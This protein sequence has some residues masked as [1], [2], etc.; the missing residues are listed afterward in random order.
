MA[1]K[2][3][4]GFQQTGRKIRIN[5][6]NKFRMSFVCVKRRV[7]KALHIPREGGADRTRRITVIL[8]DTQ[9]SAL[10]GSRSL[11]LAVSWEYT[12]RK[13]EKTTMYKEV[14]KPTLDVYSGETN[15]F[16]GEATFELTPESEKEL[17]DWV[18]SRKPFLS[19]LVLNLN[20]R[21][22]FKDY[23]FPSPSETYTRKG[24]FRAICTEASTG[25]EVPLVMHISYN[26]RIR[27]LG[28]DKQYYAVEFYNI[29]VESTNEVYF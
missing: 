7:W 27:S 12:V 24:I 4:A 5:R 10:Q 15:Q 22:A 8:P 18:N 19:L 29:N 21:P 23:V 28:P 16:F 17:L 3:E 6:S 13:G 9:F 20:F 26:M 11:P 1:G 14:R 25:A 2:S